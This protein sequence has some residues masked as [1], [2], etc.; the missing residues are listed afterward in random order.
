MPHT[1]Q[2]RC[3]RP[4]RYPRVAGGALT[5][6]PGPH[7]LSELIFPARYEVLAYHLGDQLA[8]VL[9][10]PEEA[11][12]DLLEEVARALIARGEGLLLPIHAPSGTGKTT[13]ANNLNIFLPGTFAP[14]LSFL[15]DVN[16]KAL[17]EATEKHVRSLPVNDQK[18][19]PVNIDHRE[20]S[21]PNAT[22]LASIKRFLRQYGT[23]HRILLI[24]PETSDELSTQMA[25]SYVA[26][27]GRAPISVPLKI[28][29]PPQETWIDI[30]KTTLRLANSLD[31]LEDLGVDP[32]DYDPAEH[33]SVGE[34]LRS[35]SDD[36]NQLTLRMIRATR[37]PLRLAVV[38]ASE[39]SD[40]GVLT[41][42][43][44]SNRFGLMD[45][46]ALLDASPESEVG[47][48]W[49]KH[50]GLLTSAI[51]RLDARIFGFP[52]S[53]SISV[54]RKYGPSAVQE[55]L[56]DMDVRI[57][58]EQRI[59]RNIERCD[60]GKYLL[61]KSKATFETKGTPTTTSLAAFQLIGEMGF[62]SGKD[63]YLN[64]AMAQAL[65]SFA[66]HNDLT[67]TASAEKSLE[68]YPLIPDN[69]LTY[70][71]EAICLEYT[72]RKGEFLVAKH[73]ATI[74]AYCLTKLR[75][76]CRELGWVPE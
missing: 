13:L 46:N 31:S 43:T 65:G 63:K 8:S 52:P 72:W 70:S 36:F 14:T 55:Q 76:Y 23:G 67:F 75:N 17:Q 40:A 50:R 30:A 59:S 74:A 58:G 25:D 64:Q 1:G 61:G 73:R 66:Q 2:V 6:S 33:S 35:I 34:Y 54:L 45:A 4:F 37:K 60:I 32:S 20:G 53:A 28:S 9:V 57:Y 11:T 26:I 24:W 48:W 12:R 19:I 21:P 22:E 5:E 69:L 16:A 18:I 56:R 10:S 47:R 51:V 62:T 42:L 29:G 44:S 71:H 68:F 27:A 15:G 39:S 41:H 49:K 3:R 38:F 7:L